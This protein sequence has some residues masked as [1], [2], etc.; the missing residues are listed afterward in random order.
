M[1][2]SV[3]VILSDPAPDA[4]MS[5]PDY[6]QT[7]HDH[8]AVLV[9]V[10]QIGS[11]I[12]QKNFNRIFDRIARVNHI[13]VVD[14]NGV[15]R[16]VISRYVKDYPVENNDWG[17]YQT[18]R[19]VLG[20]ISVGKYDGQQELN[21]LCRVHESLKVK[22]SST[23]F[24]SRSVLLGL[25][26]CNSYAIDASGST[27][28]ENILRTPSNFKTR[29]LFYRDSESC[30]GIET[31][32]SE[33]LSSLFWVLES[34][35]L[36][37]SREK[38]DRVS[39]LLAPFEKKDF[40]GLDLESRSSRKRCVGRM[41]K[42]LG[43]LS[44]QAGMLGDALS[45]YSSAADILRS[46]NDW[47]WLAG[48]FEGLCA[49]SVVVLYPDLSRSV[50]LQRNA[51]L[52][53]GSP[54][55]Q[56]SNS[57]YSN[58]LPNG[59]TPPEMQQDIQ[60][61][62]PQ[63]EIPKRY[64]EAIIHYSKYQNAGVI[65]T[66]ACF[67][68]ARVAVEQGYTLQAASFLQNVIFINLPLNEQEKIQR[69][70]NLS[71]LYTQ[72]GF[73]RKAAF[74]K[75]LAATRYVSAQNPQP[76]WSQCYHLM[77]QAL[78]GHKLSLDPTDFPKDG[79]VHGWPVLQVQ[80]VQE[81]V[82]AARRM[83]HSALA[84][85]HTTFLLQALW[86]ALSQAERK[87][88]AMQLQAL[89]AQCEGAPVPLVLDSGTVVP[90]ANLTHL[91]QLKCFTLQNLV[92]H[93][94]PQKIEKLKEDSGPFLFTPIHFGSLDRK[95]TSSS[96]KMDYLWVVGDTCEVHMEFY[97]L[98]PMELM[99]S[100]MRLLTNGAVFE[101]IPSS[102]C[103]PPESGPHPISLSGIPK[104]HGEL[105][106][107]GYST[108][109]LG[110][111]SNCRLRH[112]AGFPQTHFSVDI[113]PALPQMQV[114]TSLP[115]STTFSSLG[116]AAHVVTSAS[117]T[118]Y[119]GETA[120]CSVSISNVGEQPIEMLEVS[121]QSTLEPSVQQKVFQWS[122]ENLQAQL[123]LQPG[124]TASFTVYLYCVADF[125]S[126]GFFNENEMNS[127]MTGSQPVSSVSD[128]S[129]LPSRLSSPS[130]SKDQYLPR[131]AEIMSSFRS[132][133][134]S[135][136]G[137]SASSSRFNTLKMSSPTTPKVLEG[138]LKLRYSGGP[139][140]TDGYCRMCAVAI[141]IEM[142]PSIYITNWD[143]L[144]A[145]TSAQFY[146]VLDVANSTGYEMELQYTSSKCILIEASESCRIPVPVNRCPLSKLAKLYQI[147]KLTAE[148]QQELDAV[149]NDHIASFV[150][151]RWR[152][153]A[154]DTKGRISLSGI[155]LTPEMLDL[156]RM[157]PLQW[158]I[159]INQQP[160]K[161]QEEVSCHTGQCL[162]L[163][164]TVFNY[165]ERPL[166]QVVMTV[167]FYQDHQNGVNNYRLETRLAC[168]GST[169]VLLPELVEQ[170]NAYH[171]CSVIFF[172]P[173]QYKIDIQCL[174][175]DNDENLQDKN[176]AFSDV[177]H[178]WKYIPPVTI[179]VVDAE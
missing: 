161:S 175:Q 117:I 28:D 139:G 37:R 154:S 145:E 172:T 34:K 92:P 2:S 78:S 30:E 168:A 163:G 84:T 167:Q 96:S 49:A 110:V 67:K 47:L 62:L 111:K 157:S 169:K 7:A 87:D 85:R 68:A 99:V 79:S 142:L 126:P 108:H 27:G 70:T 136:S 52:Q 107:L 12:K 29:A 144:P 153:P 121:V 114:S 131:R 152:M 16:E 148:E 166:W 132:A 115:K 10:K 118:L 19:R 20:L 9:L 179:T 32:V 120:E 119:A 171:E 72:I 133:A 36:E 98:L 31:Q 138:Q 165:L 15:S 17:D 64:R 33:F 156:V 61:V 25:P 8:A 45:Y 63:E 122:Q 24:D 150:D 103:L 112:I 127:L 89:A 177:G 74:C 123:P 160:V 102:L 147:E 91:P 101:S 40:V 73:H 173:G 149:C 104:E 159:T 65:E 53:E 170:G 50:P 86:G 6:E 44:L 11:Q 81:L 77:L 105:E 75:R 162:R 151:L 54:G 93:L 18:H 130:L 35:R 42:H 13:K 66:E 174:S 109:T 178:T 176:L 141:T 43:D 83:G 14:S 80:L 21:E 143:V 158:E 134:S 137:S 106:I 100:N 94:R 58:S 56:R 124:A 55:K 59:I 76:N 69:F 46:V 164:I 48:A 95:S 97:N 88:L 116:A 23:L 125:L 128:P 3:S 71:E 22:Y 4:N 90:P 1:R 51:S 135:N 82:V 140:L 5:H 41:T 113:I 38:I 60:N 26:A 155:T 129:S 146:L 57:L 39:L